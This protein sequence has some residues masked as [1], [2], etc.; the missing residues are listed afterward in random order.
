MIYRLPRDPG[1][2]G[3]QHAAWTCPKLGMRADA[4]WH[5]EDE[6]SLYCETPDGGSEFIDYF[7][8]T[9]ACEDEIRRHFRGLMGA[10]A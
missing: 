7:P 9:A 8:S 1:I 5:S 3:G 6:W 4:Y 2:F 10:Q